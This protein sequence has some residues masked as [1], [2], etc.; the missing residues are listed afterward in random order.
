LDEVR[1]INFQLLSTSETSL[2]FKGIEDY[3]KMASAKV[4]CTER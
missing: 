2:G 4:G 1:S 3:K